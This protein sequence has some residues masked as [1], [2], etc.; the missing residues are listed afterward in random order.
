LITYAAEKRV[1]NRE[2]A[3]EKKKGPAGAL[4]SRGNLHLALFQGNT[5]ELRCQWVIVCAEEKLLLAV[6]T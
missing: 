4:L 6:S 2:R 3:R 1:L 5:F